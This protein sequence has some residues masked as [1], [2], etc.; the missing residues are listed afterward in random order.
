MPCSYELKNANIMIS[1]MSNL[2]ALLNTL[3]KMLRHLDFGFSLFLV[4]VL[5]LYTE[6]LQNTVYG[7]SYFYIFQHLY[8][9]DNGPRKP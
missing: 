9:S 8:I 2:I 3:T 7:V 1:L 5:I 4:H 6:C